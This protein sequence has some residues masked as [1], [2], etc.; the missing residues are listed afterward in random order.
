MSVKIPPTTKLTDR[1][2]AILNLAAH[3]ATIKAIATE[4][5]WSERTVKSEINTMC[6]RLYAENLTHLV[7]I[8][9]KAGL[10]P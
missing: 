1:Q 8:G 10:I 4:T 2:L 6:N 9:T 7:Y 5:S 3:G